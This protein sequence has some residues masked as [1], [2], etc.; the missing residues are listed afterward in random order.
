MK[1][2]HVLALLV[3][4]IC[5][6]VSC[7]NDD[8]PYN[9]DVLG[10]WIC[11]ETND[12]YPNLHYYAFQVGDGFVFFDG[13]FKDNLIS[14]KKCFILY[15]GQV[16][17]DKNGGM[18]ISNPTEYDWN[19][20]VY[21]EDGDYSFGDWVYILDGTS[22]TVLQC[23]LDRYVGTISLDGEIMTYTYKYQNWGAGTQLMG[24]EYGPFVAKFQKQ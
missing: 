2:F 7:N 17:I 4:F 15:D 13:E 12:E 22:L 10:K 5:V 8:E 3:L 16:Y 23:D 18:Y 24:S 14:G 11:V 19:H 21:I 6:F 9:S 20:N 1:K